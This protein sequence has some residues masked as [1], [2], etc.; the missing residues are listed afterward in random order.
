M[1]QQKKSYLLPIAM[2]FAH[3]VRGAEI[4]RSSF[5]FGNLSCGDRYFVYRSIKIS[6][7][8]DDVIFYCRGGGSDTCQIEEPMIGKIYN[9]SFV[10]GSTVFDDQCIFLFFESI[11]HFY[12]QISGESL[13]SVGRYV[14]EDD[15]VFVYLVGIPHTCMKTG[16][17]SV[18]GVGAVVDCQRVLFGVEGEFPFGD[19][20][21][22]TT[23]GG[24]QEWFGTIYYWSMLSCPR[25]TLAYFPFLSGTMMERMA[26]P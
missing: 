21:A 25:I 1:T 4:H 19:A 23:D 24:A 18:Q 16:R 7:D 15:R 20:V 5:Y 8:C 14:I 17:S 10:G 26:Q 9:S 3:S 13:F 22:I 11:S 2:M 6:I 12:F